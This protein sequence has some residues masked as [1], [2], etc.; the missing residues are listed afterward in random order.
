MPYPAGPKIILRPLV[1][2]PVSQ[3]AKAR[4][5]NAQKPLEHDGSIHFEAAHYTYVYIYAIIVMIRNND[6]NKK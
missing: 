1:T 4:P 6:K 5:S 3:R 2:L